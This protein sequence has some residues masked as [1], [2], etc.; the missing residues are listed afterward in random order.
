MITIR[1][2]KPSDID[3]GLQ[4]CRLSNWNQL[5]ADW[6]HLFSLSPEGV[7][8]AE[9]DGQICATASAVSYG[10]KI[11]WIGMILVHPDFRRLG[12]ASALMKECITHLRDL[13]VE[14][15]KL[16]AT[17]QG[18]PVYAKLGFTDERTI[19]RCVAQKQTQGIKKHKTALDWDRIRST[20]TGIFGADRTVLLKMLGRDGYSSGMLNLAA[21][22]FGYGFARDGFDASFIGPLI[23]SDIDAAKIILEDLFDMLPAGRIYMDIFPENKDALKLAEDM[24][25]QVARELMRMYLGSQ[26]DCGKTNMIYSAA[27]FELG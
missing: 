16:D 25:F 20:D 7:F 3:F 4:L 2:M 8:A 15:I 10:T 24:G 23:A 19:C 1:K 13:N 21:N 27:G 12:I 26:G 9:C 14:S 5:E 6:R 11:G 22:S 17:D 18:R